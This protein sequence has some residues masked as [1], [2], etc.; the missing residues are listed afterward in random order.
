MHLH[1]RVL[2]NNRSA[3]RYQL[4]ETLSGGQDT[5]ASRKFGDSNVASRQTPQ[6]WFEGFH[7][8]FQRTTP[9]P[10]Y[11]H[12]H[13]KQTATSGRIKQPVLADCAAYKAHIN[14]THAQTNKVCI[15]IYYCH[16]G[17]SE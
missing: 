3:N 7:G 2:K 17:Q 16:N 11:I 14:A 10:T 9:P 4:G 12:L 5:V 15:N 8:Q 13:H 6:T 1:T